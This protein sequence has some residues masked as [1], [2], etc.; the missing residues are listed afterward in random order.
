MRH[1]KD[2]VSLFRQLLLSILAERI[3][4]RPR[5]TYQ[6]KRILLKRRKRIICRGL[7]EAYSVRIAPRPPGYKSNYTDRL[8]T[9]RAVVTNE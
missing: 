4:D 8:R 3:E 1:V 7:P 5:Q 2:V 6:P 9:S